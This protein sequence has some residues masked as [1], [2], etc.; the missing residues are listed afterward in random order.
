MSVFKPYLYGAYGSNLNK[1]QMR[2]RCPDALSC[3]TLVL[4]NHLLVFRGVADIEE[5]QGES[6]T[7]GLWMITDRCEK[8][9]DRY[10]GFPHLYTKQFIDTA[11]GQVMVYTMCNQDDVCPPSYNYLESICT[12]YDDFA[13]DRKLIKPALIYSYLNEAT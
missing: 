4:K 9:L 5:A 8:A 2:R 6:V 7:L 12:G 3:E 11:A 10:E 13:I 1:A